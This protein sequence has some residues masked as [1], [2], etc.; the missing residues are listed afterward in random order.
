[1][2]N[3]MSKYTNNN[4]APL[5]S[6]SMYDKVMWIAQYGL[7]ALGALYFGLA[8]L[9]N[10]GYAAQIVGTISLVDIFL[11]VLLGISNRAYKKSDARYDGAL[12]VDTSDPNKD[13]YSIEVAAPLEKL[14][15]AESI[16]LKV[17]N[18]SG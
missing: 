16:T 13:V 8:E 17:E 11:G 3:S 10:L 7:P 14:S 4:K 12:V 18:P 5:F 6:N 9:W 2:S 1:M 15:T